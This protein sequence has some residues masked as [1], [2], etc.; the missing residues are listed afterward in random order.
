MQRYSVLNKNG[1]ARVTTDTT[2]NVNGSLVSCITVLS[3]GETA[4]KQFLSP[5]P[6]ELNLL[7]GETNFIYDGTSKKPELSASN[8]RPGDDVTLTVKG[9]ASLVGTYTA[10]ASLSGKDSGRYVLSADAEKTF[11]IQPSQT[12]FDGGLKSF[13]DGTETT[14]F[15]YGDIITITVTP[16]ATG[17]SPDAAENPKVLLSPTN[18]QMALFFGDHQLSAFVNADTSGTYTLTY[19]TASGILSPGACTLTAA[20]RGDTNM[21]DHSENITVQLTGD[22]YIS[23][24][25]LAPTCETDG[26][27][28]HYK[29]KDGKLFINE[30]GIMKEVTF[31]D[32]VLSATGH[33]PGAWIQDHDKHYQECLNGCGQH[34]HEGNC[35]GGSA[36]FP[37]RAVCDICGHPYGAYP[38][39]PETDIPDPDV[40]ENDSPDSEKPNPNVPDGTTP[41]D[42]TSGDGTSDEELPSPE[43]FTPQLPSSEAL[44]AT[45]QSASEKVSEKAVE[46][47]DTAPMKLL[48]LTLLSSGLISMS[49]YRSKKNML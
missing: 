5:Q 45:S 27:K 29:D 47:G 49:I 6:T 42:E 12:I 33:Q 37:D 23:V 17:L 11:T 44:A 39:E 28:A 36:I 21:V 19:Q 25:F 38:E 43:A 14:N 1:Q 13:C 35:T 3:T 26:I 15:A 9:E 24:D 48:F 46:T 2:G 18:G 20:F 41:D 40:P 32:L 30:N 8:I 34:L 22:N 16:K 31:Q 4:W 10:T 7:W